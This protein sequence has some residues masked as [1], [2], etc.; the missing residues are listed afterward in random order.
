MLLMESSLDSPGMVGSKTA[1]AWPNI[2]R[3]GAPGYDAAPS[4]S[5][6]LL[7]EGR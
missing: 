3:G 5:K 6:S 4:L 2:R 1:P 7:A